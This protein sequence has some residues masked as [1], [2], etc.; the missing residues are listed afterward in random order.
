MWGAWEAWGQVDAEGALS[1]WSHGLF[2]VGSSLLS[3]PTSA[4]RPQLLFSSL[5][6]LETPSQTISSPQSPLP[7]REA[8]TMATSCLEPLW[9]NTI[10]TTPQT[11]TLFTH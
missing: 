5:R 9:L 1:G 10:D 3:F 4:S 7:P 2:L 11:Y 8:A 6:F